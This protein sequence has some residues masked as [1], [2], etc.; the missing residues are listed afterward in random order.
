ASTMQ[1]LPQVKNQTRWEPSPDL[2]L[3]NGQRALYDCIRSQN[4]RQ[5]LIELPTGYG[6]SWCAC[7]A[8]AVMKSQ[9][10]VDRC[11]IVVPTDQQRS[12]YYSGLQDDLDA[13]GVAYKGI[14]RCLNGNPWVIKKSIRNESDIFIAGVGSI[15][16]NPSYYSDLMSKG[17]WLVVV[18]ELHHFPEGKSWGEAVDALPYDVRMGMS[19]TP[20][21]R[22]NKPTIFGD[23]E[24]D[25]RVSLKDAFEEGAIRKLKSRILD[26]TLTYSKMGE[27]P[28]TAMLSDIGEEV[29]GDISAWELKKGVRYFAKYVS[30]I[31]LATI[32][33]WL[34]YESLYPGQNQ[35]LVF[36]MS[37]KH[38]ESIAGIINDLAPPG[39]TDPFADWIGVGE[40]EDKRSPK[41]NEEILQRFQDNKLPCLVQ[42]NKAG[43]GFN[44][45]RCSIGLMLD[46]VGDTPQKRQHIGRFL[47][48]NSEAPDCEAVVFISSDH[49]CR[50]LLI[51]LE[52][53]MPTEKD[54]KSESGRNGDKDI[55][56]KI[57]DIFILNT[58]YHS[59]VTVYPYGSKEAAISKFLEECPEAKSITESMPDAKAALETMMEHWV[60][61][62]I[63]QPKP[64]SSEEERKI[65]QDQVKR[66][67]GKLVNAVLSKRF[68][69]SI[70]KTALKDYY[71]AI[72]SQWKKQHGS[73]ST[74][75]KEDLIAKNKWL[76]EIAAQVND[77][78]FPTWLSL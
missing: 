30:S 57:P 29:S 43:E 5:Y 13:L 45:K 69:K 51:N 34:E 72:H 56:L 66:N 18:D 63:P 62:H 44:N 14:E 12:Q 6:K 3:R 37:C 71:S 50:E 20:L 31:F 9:S 25:V 74:A 11:L 53:Q 35:I 73:Q 54:G 32:N 58:E 55:Q 26:Y 19:A 33:Q 41:Q 36:A 40:A 38:A 46:M 21:R 68:G 7:I 78:G 17:S 22:D 24:F 52:D 65:V 59:E 28:T 15:T 47:R 75:T 67:T 16:A 48:V 1:T 70:P 61:K 60:K 39:I 2:S 76:Q 10:R 42:V 23:A 64:L 4:K 8:Y 49:P 77:G 27:D